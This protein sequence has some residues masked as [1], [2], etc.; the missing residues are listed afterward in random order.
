MRIIRIPVTLR[1]KRAD[2]HE[3]VN[4]V[5]FVLRVALAKDPSSTVQQNARPIHC[6]R[7]RLHESA[8]RIRA[9]VNVTLCPCIDGSSS[10]TQDN[11]AAN[12][13]DSSRDIVEL[14]VV[15]DQGASELSVAGLRR[16]HEDRRIGHDCVSDSLCSDG[17]TQR[18]K[19]LESAN[20]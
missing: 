12:N 17:L 14:D 1:T 8:R 15:E 6:R 18:V 16:T 7:R 13:T 19:L 11:G 2:A 20:W 3:L 4:S 9:R 10:S 5:V